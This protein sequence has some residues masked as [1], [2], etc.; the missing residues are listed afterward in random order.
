MMY[1]VVT[2]FADMQDRNRVYAPGDTFPRDGAEVRAER[3]A[4]LAGNGNRLGV[5]VIEAV[6]EQEKPRRTK[7][8]KE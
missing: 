4:Y 7:K 3:L 8:T 1:R 2:A 5:P 6:E